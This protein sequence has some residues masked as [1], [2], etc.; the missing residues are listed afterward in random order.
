MPPFPDEG[1]DPEALALYIELLELL[2]QGFPA[3]DFG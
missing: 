1:W 2:S 3:G